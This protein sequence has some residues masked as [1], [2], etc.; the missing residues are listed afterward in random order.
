VLRELGRGGQGAVFLA[1]DTRIARRVAL[2]V[3]GGRFDLVSEERRRRLRREAEVIARLEHPGICT[4]LEAEIEG[5]MP[6]LAMRFVEGRT[7]AEELAEARAGAGAPRTTVAIRE[8]LAYFERAARAL[9]AAH[10]AGVVH[11]DVKPGNLM[12]TP[13]GTPVLLDFGLAREPRAGELSELTQPGDLHGTPAYMAPEQLELPSSELDRRCDVYSLG[14]A[15]YEA[16]TLHAPF[17]APTPAQLY[18]AIARKPLPEPQAHNRALSDEV[19]VVLATALEKDR[20]RRYASALELAEDLRRIREYEPIHARPASLGL[21]FARWVRRNPVLAATLAALS[22]GLSVALWAL[23]GEREA[24]RFALGKHLATRCRELIAEDPSAAL[25]LGIQACELAPN[26]I[27]RAALLEALGACRLERELRC[28]DAPAGAMA[29]APDGRSIAVAFRAASDP[30]WPSCVRVFDLERREAFVECAGGGAQLTGVVWA[31]GGT[32][33]GSALDGK[34]R[35]WDARDGRVL[36]E[37]DL[38]APLLALERSH[39]GTRALA[40]GKDFVALVELSG[41]QRV[42][43]C[44]LEA[45]GSARPRFSGDDRWFYVARGSELARFDARD[46]AAAGRCTLPGPLACFACDPRRERVLCGIGGGVVLVEELAAGELRPVDPAATVEFVTFSADGERALACTAQGACLIEPQRLVPIAVGAPVVHA[47]FSPDGRRL[48][49]AS[50][51]MSLRL[52]SVPEHAL[53]RVLR[54]RI[55]PQEL[56]WT[57]DGSRLWMRNAGTGGMV[58]F[59]GELPDVRR[60]DGRARAAPRE[61][62]R[63]QFTAAADGTL[64]ALRAGEAQPVWEHVARAR[65]DEKDAGMPLALHMLCVARDGSELCAAGGKWILRFAARDGAEIERMRLPFERLRSLEYSP[66]GGQLLLV[67]EPGGGAFR[68]VALDRRLERRIVAL[69]ITHLDDLVAGSFSPDGELLATASSDG[70]CYVR[71]ARGGP[72]VSMVRL[73]SAPAWLDWDGSA[74]SWCLVGGS[75]DGA[76]VLPVDPLPAARARVPRALMDWE[77]LVERRLAAPLVYDP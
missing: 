20:E 12:V 55:A 49:T 4:I 24:L 31:G 15:L 23:A 5:E 39:D 6:W 59:A 11:R 7:L 17:E 71:D 67:G 29:L 56:G 58:W 62:T 16:L 69:E 34:L 54:G 46:G 60:I 3:L 37:L 47:A 53:E 65:D 50:P 28:G 51:D 2:K 68:L 73:A 14:A 52:W 21:R 64:R 76:Q 32:L 57:A 77:V 66:A 74:G 44:A 41:L 8:R 61:D 18:F 19:A 10:E 42:Q 43:R 27:T 45:L 33:V 1:E 72:P 36:R 75:G 63:L 13:A 22:I 25:V 35:A 38:G 26:Y 30:A 40:A 70:V 48:A 9:H